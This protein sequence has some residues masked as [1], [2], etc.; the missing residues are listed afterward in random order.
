MLGKLR[1][2]FSHRRKQST[3]HS[4][5]PL[6]GAGDNLAVDSP[7]NN[8]QGEDS[9][10]IANI[11]ARCPPARASPGTNDAQGPSRTGNGANV[12]GLDIIHEP[13][14]RPTAD[15]IFVHGLGGHSHKTWSKDRNIDFFWPGLWLPN[16]PQLR[17]ARLF[18]YGYDSQLLGPKSVSN[19]M[20]FAR[21]LLFDMRYGRGNRVN[22]LKIGE[23][24]IV[25]VA[26]SMGGLVVKK[27]YLMAQNDQNCAKIS[28]SIV[29]IMFLS[30][31]HRGSNLSPVLNLTLRATFQP[32]KTF[33]KELERNSSAIEDINDQ[34]RHVAPNLSIV[35]FYEEHA[36]PILGKRLM[37]VERDSAIL[38]YI[39]EDSRGL[40]ADHHTI[41]KFDSEEDSKYRIVRDTLKDLVEKLENGTLQTPNVGSLVTR[42]NIEKI[43]G[44]SRTPAED[45]NSLRKRWVPGSCEWFLQDSGTQ[46]WLTNPSDSHLIWYNAPPAHGKSVLSSYVIHYLQAEG[47]HCQYY[48]FNFGDQTRRSISGMLRSLAHQISSIMP[49]YKE[50][51]FT[52]CAEDIGFDEK[53]YRFLWHKLFETLLFCKT[54]PRPLFWVI[55]GLDE[56]ES[57]QTIVEL[58]AEAFSKAK[59]QIKVLVTSRR[60]EALAWEIKKV[61]R[62]L[63]VNVIDGNEHTHNDGDIKLL[64]DRELEHL[65]G[66]TAVRERLRQEILKRASGNFLWVSIVLDNLYKWQTESEIRAMLEQIPE[67][68]TKMY[69]QMLLSITENDNKQRVKLAKELLQWVVCAPQPLTLDQLRDGISKEYPDILDLK[70]T[71]RDVCGNFIFISNTNHVM[72]I[73]QTARDFL[74]ND[75][76][77]I[78][79]LDR[80][81]ASSAVLIKSLSSISNPST[82]TLAI[83]A[84]GSLS[85]RMELEAQHP[86]SIYAANSWFHYLEYA[87]SVSAEALEALDTFFG[88][89]HVLDWIYILTVKDEV[90]AL[91]RAGSALLKFVT[92]NHRR[93]ISIDHRL[94]TFELL[95]NWGTD[96]MR[97][98][99]K[100]TRYLTT[101]PYAIYEI[102]PALSPPTSMI[103]RQF[104][105]C[106]GPKITIS[107]QTESWTDVFGRFSL[108][109]DEIALKI[110]S[111][112]AHLAVLTR[113]GITRVWSSTD[114]KGI[115][116]LRHGEAV[117][118][119]CMNH[120]GDMLVTYGLNTTMVWDVPA[121]TV[122]L[123]VPNIGNSR[124]M[125]L[126]FAM[127]DQRVLAAT[128]DSV[129]RFLEIAEDGAAWKVLDGSLLKE[130]PRPDLV[131]MNSPSCVVFNA[132][133]TQIGVCYRSFPLTVWDLNRAT[134]IRRCLRPVVPSDP[135]SVSSPT[136]F[137]VEFFN[138]NPVTGHIIGW[139]KGNNLFKWHP[140]TDETHEV[141]ACVDGLVCSPNGKS[142][143]TSN[144]DGIVQLWDFASFNVTYQLSSG[145][146]I[147]GLSFSPDSERFY[148]IRGSTI[149]AWEPGGLV[150][151][152]G[153]GEAFGGPV[154]EKQG[155][156]MCSVRQVKVPQSPNLIAISSAPDGLRYVTANDHGEVHLADV[157]D[158]FKIELTR[159]PNLVCVSHLVWSPR[160]GM[161][162]V[163]D[164][165]ADVRIL[166]IDNS[167][168]SQLKH[169]RVQL[170]QRP[171]LSLGGGAIHQMLVDF[172][173]KMLLV[174]TD[175]LAQLW[176]IHDCCVKIS[177]PMI[178]AAQHSW[179]N[180]PTNHDLFL[181]VGP[182]YIKVFQWFSL[183]QMY[184]INLS[185]T[186]LSLARQPTL[187][188][189][190][191]ETTHNLT[192]DDSSDSRQ[193]PAMKIS[194]AI[195][196][197]D[198][199]HVLIYLRGNTP[200]SKPQKKLLVLPVKAMD[201][202]TNLGKEAILE[203][204]EVRSDLVEIL[205]IPLGILAGEQLIF[206]DCDFWLCSVDLTRP[207]DMDVRRH[208]FIP[209]DWTSIEG[210]AQSLVLPEGTLLCIQEGN[211]VTIRSNLISIGF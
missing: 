156:A 205:E 52:T 34:F 79:E 7:S 70:K 183:Q 44:L 161:I 142:F 208:Y 24:P 185:S 4:G 144:S 12:L 138:W 128:D 13:Q 108:S 21:S 201:A 63:R 36:T 151:I 145:D 110:V 58:L 166:Q 15:I 82:R 46:L 92:S 118:D 98:A 8:A 180:Q 121:G 129:V 88:G 59:I 125:S 86:F 160:G 152:S 211:V 73:H 54:F 169:T 76:N 6:T 102:I 203:C 120:R 200:G 41:C 16:D 140:V 91:A 167:I 31:P 190:M 178:G 62:L 186:L 67:N 93:K 57:S 146:L 48:F 188:P 32:G 207:A 199:K 127:N 96:L 9:G 78:S 204:M 56:S 65:P 105:Q 115:C 148:D 149:T 172:S 192:A 197:Q 131:I 1:V 173:S 117:V 101:Q 85:I 170:I 184:Q 75:S 136:W 84:K 107:G 187:T 87:G 141:P 30:T 37:I 43:L 194:K 179:F 19:I 154:G 209:R 10:S 174:L 181:G 55:D 113:G 116:T 195:F 198:G 80:Q 162:V 97:I 89:P 61:E 134:I 83:G 23:A 191:D 99:A 155:T 202:A 51:I 64:V 22:S 135:A 124:A 168:S 11:P 5:Q 130:N 171:K 42:K 25:F 40:P 177:A 126:T 193:K 210:L 112:G 163:A 90:G 66:N 103:N 77:G 164:L 132:S 47:H 182:E 53:D 114:F 49:E 143:V 38:G 18:T 175:K 123:R 33:I 104:R 133:G 206:F 28:R 111:T 147:S 45:F 14:S 157:R 95:G 150:Q 29:G 106:K 153:P 176:S 27:A 20:G 69:S 39:N 196:T 71:V 94:P 17:K 50:E 119:M 3:Q 109:Q 122:R 159:F 72:M 60:T 74:T 139:Y 2:G 158:T 189:L 100:F 35:S 81:S 137:P 26:H 165:T 68:M